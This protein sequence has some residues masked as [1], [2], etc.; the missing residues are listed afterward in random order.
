MSNEKRIIEINGV[1]LEVD[2]STARKV[3]EFKVGDN[4]KVLKK[5]YNSY[6]V[7]PD[8]II[9]F[10]NFKSLPTIVIAILENEYSPQIEFVYYNAELEG[11]EVV[12]TCEHELI[13]EKNSVLQKMERE[14]EKKQAEIAD[15]VAK[16]QY[17]LK[18]FDKHFSTFVE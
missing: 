9:E 16:K 10:V 18:H 5:S 7:C 8:V 4:V 12:L 11:V 1:K 13:L 17:F 14:I 6:K 3:D 15:I 2:L